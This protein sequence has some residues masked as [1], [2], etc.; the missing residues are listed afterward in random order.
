MATKADQSKPFKVLIIGGG[1]VGS[2]SAVY[3]YNRNCTVTL[4][5]QRKDLRTVSES[6]GK[7][8]NL[9]LSVRGI[10]ALEAANVLKNIEKTLIPMDG[11]M[12]IR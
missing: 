6:A 3:F 9:A 7:S 2:L 5:E 11:R 12:S 1:L 10:A 8:I 4:I